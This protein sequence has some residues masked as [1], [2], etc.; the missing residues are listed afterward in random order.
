MMYFASTGNPELDW[1][2]HALI[3]FFMT[4]SCIALFVTIFRHT[5]TEYAVIT[6]QR[7]II[8]RFHGHSGRT[9]SFDSL[10]HDK[11]GSRRKIVRPDG[12][13]SLIFTGTDSFFSTPKGIYR[14]P[15]INAVE[16]I[17]IACR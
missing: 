3:S 1:F 14:V 5:F 6:D 13:G 9:I 12:S 7:V 10:P 2:L 17:L 16:K 11:T 15:D 8:A 4:L